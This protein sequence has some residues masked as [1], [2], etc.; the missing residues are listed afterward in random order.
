MHFYPEADKH[1]TGHHITRSPR[2][3]TICSCLQRQRID[4]AYQKTLVLVVCALITFKAVV[5]SALLRPAR[6]IYLRTIG[7]PP[8]NLQRTSCNSKEFSCAI[9]HAEMLHPE[10]LPCVFR[11]FPVQT[12]D[13]RMEIP[14]CA[15][16]YRRKREAT[17]GHLCPTP[18]MREEE[19]EEEEQ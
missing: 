10:T 4:R 8:T 13:A 14:L 1:S 11:R 9:T 15:P 18:N 3:I 12:A 7:Q 6:R 2:R 19:V 5:R 17:R 16:L